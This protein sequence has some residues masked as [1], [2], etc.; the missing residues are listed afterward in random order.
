MALEHMLLFS[1]V[2]GLITALLLKY[3]LKHEPDL[4][5]ALRAREA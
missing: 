1:V 5:Y 4:V 3:F 2:E